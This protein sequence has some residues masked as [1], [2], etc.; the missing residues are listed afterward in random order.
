LLALVMLAAAAVSVWT[1]FQIDRIAARWFST[2]N[3]YWLWPL[4]AAT[5]ALA[6][7]I[8]RAAGDPAAERTP[9]F[10]AIGVFLLCYLGLAISNFPYL[11]PPT[12]TVWDAAAVPASQK[13]MLWGVIVM[14][15][16]ILGYTV[17][18]YWTF[19]GK[20]REGEGYH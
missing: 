7:L 16:V 14:L 17:F 8:W 20:V 2:P 15:P 13:F 6:A 4:P 10:G 9:F 19:R 1:P 12:L 18:V 3:L 11:A 5:A